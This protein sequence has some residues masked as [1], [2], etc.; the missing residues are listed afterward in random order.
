MI[1]VE[2]SCCFGKLGVEVCG[3]GFSVCGLWFVVCGLWF[4]MCKDF[5]FARE[6]DKRS[7]S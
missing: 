6:S 3:S 5:G 7:S 1:R 2:E 4:V